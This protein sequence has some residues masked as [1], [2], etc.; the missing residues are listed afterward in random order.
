MTA[1]RS[2]VPSVLFL[3]LVG[4]LGALYLVRRAGAQPVES[5]EGEPRAGSSTNAEVQTSASEPAEVAGAPHVTPSDR[6]EEL[7]PAP[8]AGEET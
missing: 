3:A 1:G 6:L 7:E 4:L 5:V 2:V 8:A